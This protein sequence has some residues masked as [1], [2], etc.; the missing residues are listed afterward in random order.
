[1]E[2]YAGSLPLCPCYTPLH[3]TKGPGKQS[4]RYMCQLLRQTDHH[5]AESHT[6][7]WCC[8]YGSKNSRVSLGTQDKQDKGKCTLFYCCFCHYRILA[9]KIAA[10]E[11][12]KIWRKPTEALKINC[13]IA[14]SRTGKP[15]MVTLKMQLNCFTVCDMTPLGEYV[16]VQPFR[17]WNRP[18]FI[19]F[20]R[21]HKYFKGA[22]VMQ[23]NKI[24][25]W[26]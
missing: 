2:T 12:C 11:V 7:W 3:E 25:K 20:R 14:E 17:M 18:I 23:I 1:M 21:S 26:I 5:L 19:H 13:Q 22:K 24:L 10:C 15:A 16:C 4:K 6:W 8:V 9:Y